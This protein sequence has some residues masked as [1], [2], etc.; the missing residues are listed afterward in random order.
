MRS[1]YACYTK[2]CF[3]KRRGEESREGTPIFK[4]EAFFLSFF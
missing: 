1:A 2:G 3:F 4:Q